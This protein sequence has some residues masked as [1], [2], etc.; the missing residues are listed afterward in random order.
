MQIE[1]YQID[2]L[3]NQHLA[4]HKR[5]FEFVADGMPN[6]GCGVTVVITSEVIA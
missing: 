5:R 3:N 1:K 4:M 2:E 6:I